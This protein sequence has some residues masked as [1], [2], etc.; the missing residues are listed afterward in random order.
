[1][2]EQLQSKSPCLQRHAPQRKRVAQW[3]RRFE[4]SRD[5]WH[6]FICVRDSSRSSAALSPH[7]GNDRSAPRR[8]RIACLPK[9]VWPS[10]T[11]MNTHVYIH[12]IYICTYPHRVWGEGV[13]RTPDPHHTHARLHFRLFASAAPPPSVRWPLRRR[14]REPM[15][16]APGGDCRA[17]HGD[18][19]S[20]APPRKKRGGNFGMS[21]C[22]AP[23]AHG[24][25]CRKRRPI[26]CT[27]GKKPGRTT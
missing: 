4:L 24:L 19:S 23:R 2:V 13:Y 6:D 18:R 10:Y 9:N 21:T 1:M 3:S 8:Q 26:V 20:S 5:R 17:G 14:T 22:H 25:H 16:G 7:A 12:I 15:R 27:L 11:N